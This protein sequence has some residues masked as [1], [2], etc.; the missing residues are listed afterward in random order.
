[1]MMCPSIAAKTVT[2]LNPA[3][4]VR[5]LRGA[6]ASRSGREKD[7]LKARLAGVLGMLLRHATSIDKSLA[8]TGEFDTSKTCG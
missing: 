4:Q 6:S 8:G 1:M 2:V 7:G 3:Q 5:M